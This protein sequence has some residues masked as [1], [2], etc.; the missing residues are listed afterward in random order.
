MGVTAYSVLTPP[1]DGS[2]TGHQIQRD[3]E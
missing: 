1:I 3:N 2:A